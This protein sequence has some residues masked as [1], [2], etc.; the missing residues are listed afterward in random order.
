MVSSLDFLFHSHIF[1]TG[2]QQAFN[3]ESPRGIKKKS[4]ALSKVPIRHIAGRPRTRICSSLIYLQHW[5]LSSR[6]QPT[7]IFPQ[8]PQKRNLS[9]WNHPTFQTWLHQQNLHLWTLHPKGNQGLESPA[10]HPATEG[11]QGPGSPDSPPSG[12][13]PPEPVTLGPL[14][15]YRKWYK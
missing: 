9:R 3:P 7:L 6:E 2:Y 5:H 4:L 13:E 14:P 8:H 11:K 12:R 15:S 1:R 10:P